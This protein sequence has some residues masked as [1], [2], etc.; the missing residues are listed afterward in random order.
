MTP[1]QKTAL[2]DAIRLLDE[3][4]VAMNHAH[5]FIYTR[6]KMHSDGRLLYEKTLRDLKEFVGK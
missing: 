3:C 2:R 4:Y 1:D 5:I 6:E